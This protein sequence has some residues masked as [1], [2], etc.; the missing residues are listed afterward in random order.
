MCHNHECL[1][2]VLN[3]LNPGTQTMENS[4]KI[5]GF[6]CSYLWKT[7]TNSSYGG[8]S[9]ISSFLNFVSVS[10]ALPGISLPSP[11]LSSPS[12]A[13]AGA[14][15]RPTIWWWRWATPRSGWGR[16][17][18]R[19]RGAVWSSSPRSERGQAHWTA[20]G[21]EWS[22]FLLEG[23][24][25][26]GHRSGR[27]H[28]EGDDGAAAWSL[29][30]PS[31]QRSRNSAVTPTCRSQMSKVLHWPTPT[32]DPCQPSQVTTKHAN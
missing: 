13:P 18:R 14:W 15:A 1:I 8:K 6:F 26:S 17:R 9:S 29:S 5:K 31:C 19:R 30:P 28:Q 23:R 10:H 4:K 25:L 22:F 21:W 7:F 12:S 11:P 32:P 3:F 27:M 16:A 2:R 24:P 20:N